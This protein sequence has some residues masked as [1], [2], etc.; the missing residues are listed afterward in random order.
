M[1]GSASIQAAQDAA[2]AASS[3]G[4][5]C[6]PRYATPCAFDHVFALYFY[7]HP[8]PSGK[9]PRPGTGERVVPQCVDRLAASRVWI[10]ALS[11]CTCEL[12]YVVQN[13]LQRQ[14]LRAR[15]QPMLPSRGE[16]RPYGRLQAE[17]AVSRKTCG[18]FPRLL[19]FLIEPRLNTSAKFANWLRRGRRRRWRTGK[20]AWCGWRGLP[21][22][23]HTCAQEATRNCGRWS[24]SYRSVCVCVCLPMYA[25]TKSGW[26][27]GEP[28]TTTL[29]LV[30]GLSPR[31][32][33]SP[34]MLYYYNRGRNAAPRPP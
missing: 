20:V 32:T 22:A 17:A 12:R 19:C 10:P 24:S 16:G 8:C 13:V 30:F 31:Q 4:T 9:K 28:R 7:F 23:T 29:R 15:Q 6:F 2:G 1:T 34:S 18:Q 27:M 33:S 14:C 5:D 11:Q 26:P 3:P 21:A 25:R